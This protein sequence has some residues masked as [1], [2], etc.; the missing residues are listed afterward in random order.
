MKRP[1]APHEAVHDAAVAARHGRD[2]GRDLLLA[3][4]RLVRLDGPEAH[5]PVAAPARDQRRVV[6]GRC[7]A[8]VDRVTKPGERLRAP[9]VHARVDWQWLQ[10]HARVA[11]RA[12]GH[13]AVAR[14]Q[15]PRECTVG[16][17]VGATVGRGG[18]ARAWARG[19]PSHTRGTA[20]C[21][22]LSQSFLCTSN[23]LDGLRH[24]D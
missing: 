15:R 19:H 12:C 9:P 22:P 2:H 11:P 21:F 3:S 1:T 10:V 23:L 18:G 4:A 6:R 5:G 14:R 20:S 7:G 8:A 16:T 24:P 13:D 17:W